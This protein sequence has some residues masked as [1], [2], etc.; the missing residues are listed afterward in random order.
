M[1]FDLDELA[2]RIADVCGDGQVTRGSRELAAAGV[3]VGSG[4]PA[5]L[6]RPGAAAEIA[7]IMRLA[8]ARGV[9]VVPV[10]TAS[11]KRVPVITPPLVVLDMK[12][13]GHVLHLDETSLIVH[14]QAGLTGLALEDLLL[15]RG[16]SLGDYA[17]AAIKSTLGGILAVRTPGK[18]TPRHGF[19]E[20]AVL[21]VSAVLADGR[22]IHTRIAP[23]R[24]TG[25]DLA[26]AL[27][28]SEGSLGVITSVVLR[29]HR[30]AETR[31][32]EAYRLPSL[33]AAVSVLRA[34]LREDVRP[35]A[36]R[37]YDDHEAAAHLP[38]EGGIRG[39]AVLTVALAGPPAL[40]QVERQILAETVGQAGG[41]DLPSA[42]AEVWWRRRHGH[43]AGAP[44]PA[45]PALEFVAP[46][47]HIAATHAAILVAASAAGRRARAHVS[48]FDDDGAV[49][50]VTLLDG[51]RPDPHGPARL[52]VIDAAR[53]AGAHPPGERDDGMAPY[54]ADLRS[55]LDPKGTLSLL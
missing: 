31:A 7:E 40:V 6:V 38:I 11:R 15:P 36:T 25:P 51:E 55:A 45:P 5:L 50:F 26:R 28:G 13:L 24:A 2:A 52:R 37:I 29:I 20:D 23:R 3:P 21:G 33:A 22:S 27:L 35:G 42:L 44:P 1:G 34:I 4:V 9:R 32:L 43:S 54:Y 19:V 41:S 16:L 49:I 12:R 18:G 39:E 53:K 14:A 30:R 47:A 48:R 10:G 46:F 17:P 8:S